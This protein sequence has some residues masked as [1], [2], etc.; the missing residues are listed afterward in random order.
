MTEK[1]LTQQLKI[2]CIIKFWTQ[3]H[4]DSNYVKNNV[5]KIIRKSETVKL[6]PKNKKQLRK[7]D[8]KNWTKKLKTEI[9]L[10]KKIEKKSSQKAENIHE[11]KKLKSLT[12]ERNNS[13]RNKTATLWLW[14]QKCDAATPVKLN[15]M[16][17]NNC[18]EKKKKGTKRKLLLL[19]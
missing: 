14:W 1:C 8:I 11:K 12:T 13:A 3:E 4:G 7:K 5:F 15:L 6:E 16:Q 9:V 10:S 2:I 19:S 17:Q 18:K